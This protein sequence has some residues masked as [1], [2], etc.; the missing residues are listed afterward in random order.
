MFLKL[1]KFESLSVSLEYHEWLL[2]WLTSYDG[3]IVNQTPISVHQY[4]VRLSRPEFA[5]HVTEVGG[6]AIWED[7]LPCQ[8]TVPCFQTHWIISTICEGKNPY[9]NIK[10]V[11]FNG[12]ILCCYGLQIEI[13]KF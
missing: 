10:L 4:H 7:V 5:D 8:V 3:C 12:Y 9:E 13:G 1:L 6:D 11:G 2:I